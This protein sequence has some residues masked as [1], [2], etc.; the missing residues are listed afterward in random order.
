MSTSAILMKKIGERETWQIFYSEILSSSAL[1]HAGEGEAIQVWLFRYLWH[2][3]T[4]TAVEHELIFTWLPS[5]LSMKCKLSRGWDTSG[6]RHSSGVPLKDNTKNVSIEWLPMKRNEARVDTPQ[7]NDPAKT[8]TWNFRS[9]TTY[10]PPHIQTL[11][12]PG[13][14][15]CMLGCFVWLLFISL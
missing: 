13:F 6:V 3:R 10:T 7:C 9:R 2:Q 8:S 1:K 4:L 11:Q 12:Q 5:P 15:V 14:I